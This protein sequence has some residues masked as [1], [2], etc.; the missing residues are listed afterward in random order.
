MVP[1]A[2]RVPGEGFG[3]EVGFDINRAPPPTN[4]Y[5]G[6]DDQ[7]QVFFASSIP[8]ATAKV[9]A[10]ILLP[11]G[12]I[13][14]NEWIFTAINGR[15]GS[16]FYQFLAEGFMLSLSV[17]SLNSTQPG[18]SYVRLTLMRGTQNLSS[19]SVVL[20]AGYVY[21]QNVVSWPTSQLWP[22]S[23]GR[24]AMRVINGTTP[25]PG[26]EI[27]EVVPSNVLWRLQ[28]FS[29]VLNTSAAVANRGVLLVFDN[30]VASYSYSTATSGQPAGLSQSYTF[31]PGYP[32]VNIYPSQVMAPAPT[33]HFIPAGFRIRTATPSLQAGDQYSTISYLV[34][35]W[36]A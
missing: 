34:E 7:L 19:N 23:F 25:A 33:D 3:Q 12:K 20:L 9:F 8:G 5:I 16:N 22:M 6:A 30:G 27:T 32:L 2:T 15:V 14:P 17:A 26:G 13:V 11:N 35:E 21:G 18:Q 1:E 4:A 28:T 36:L 10:R 29:F 24:G 31:A